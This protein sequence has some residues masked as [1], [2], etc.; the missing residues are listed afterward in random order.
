MPPGVT[1]SIDGKATVPVLRRPGSSLPATFN[2]YVLV[3]ADNQAA[4][5]NEGNNYPALL[6]QPVF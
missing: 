1:A 6:S 5:T 3:D 4:E 2:F